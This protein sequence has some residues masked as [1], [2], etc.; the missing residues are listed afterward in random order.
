[1][2]QFC[3]VPIPSSSLGSTQSN[4]TL[5]SSISLL[6]QTSLSSQPALPKHSSAVK[7]KQ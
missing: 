7:K 2:A 1:M 6:A 5:P 3:P 4:A